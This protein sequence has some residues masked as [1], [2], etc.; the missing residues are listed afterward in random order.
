VL[1][2]TQVRCK[3]CAKRTIAL[4]IIMILQGDMGH[5]EPHFGPFGDS[6]GIGARYVHGL[7]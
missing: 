6:V 2:L 7:C 5:V 4:E 3:V 1:I